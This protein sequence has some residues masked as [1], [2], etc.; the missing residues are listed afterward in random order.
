MVQSP[1]TAAASS[2]LLHSHRT[3][4]KVRQ[5]P[6]HTIL[7]AY[8]SRTPTSYGLFDFVKKLIPIARSKENNKKESTDKESTSRSKSKKGKIGDESLSYET[9]SSEIEDEDVAGK[10]K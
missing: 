10:I 5:S 7:K 6:P 3:I 9:L 2:L 4:I 8:F 1:L